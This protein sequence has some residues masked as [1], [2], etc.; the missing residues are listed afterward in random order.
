MKKLTGRYKRT[1]LH[2]SKK[3]QKKLR[4]RLSRDRYYLLV[5][6]WDGEREEIVVCRKPPMLPPNDINF[7]QNIDQTLE[8]LK[9]VRER[10]GRK[11]RAGSRPLTWIRRYKNRRSQI[12]AFYD[13]SVIQ[14]LAVGPA[15]VMAASYD[16]ARRLVGKT[17]PAINYASW[18]A[19]AI[20]TFFEIGF[21]DLIGQT[22]NPA[23][24]LEYNNKASNE[25]KI[26]KAIS[27][28]NAN[29]LEGCSMAIASLLVF[30]RLSDDDRDFY[31]PEINTAI[32]E[33]M[34]NVAKHAYP[35]DYVKNSN[36][37]TLN[38]WWMTARADRANSSITI[39]VYDQGASIPGTLPSRGWFKNAVQAHM[40][41]LI[42]G[43]RHSADYR[44]MDPEYINFSMKPGKTQ[45]NDRQRGLGLPQMQELI[46]QCNGGSL[47]VLSRSGYY[48]YNKHSG[49]EKK[50]L[51][52]ELEGT[53]IEWHLS[54]PDRNTP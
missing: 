34:I 41:L 30:L 4:K 31:V 1:L 5:T 32:S 6:A 8:F 3:R 10:I 54:L 13:Y 12:G 51:A 48:R 44:K 42:P 18:G 43:F 14:C 37:D 9:L 38:Q 47:T 25:I 46:D 19:S 15:L 52:V 21:F 17:P 11:R 29:G 50:F 23:I 28:I 45:T 2:R 35:Q 22:E 26:I 20:Q 53:L 40:E 27:G 24:V 39:A 16:R 49:I 33:A 7:G 36:Y